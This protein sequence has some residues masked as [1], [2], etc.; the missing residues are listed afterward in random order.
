MKLACQGNGP[1]PFMYSLKKLLKLITKVAVVVMFLNVQLV[2]A[3]AVMA[4]T[5]FGFWTKA[6]LT[7]QVICFDMQR[8]AGVLKQWKLLL[9]REILMLLEMCCQRQSYG[10][11]QS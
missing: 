11:G 9:Q 5:S 1:H 7:R 6:M 3:E 2:D 10:T 4:V 8:S